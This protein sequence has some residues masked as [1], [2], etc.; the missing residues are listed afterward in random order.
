AGS[1]QSIPI[2]FT[3]GISQQSFYHSW[4]LAG[5][6]IAPGDEIEYYFEVWDNDGVNGHKPAR[7]Q[8]MIFHAPTENEIAE[9]TEKN[10]SEIKK[11][12][13]ES[14]KKSKELQKEMD[15]LYKKILEKK[16]LS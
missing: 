4:D 6:T 10:N 3:R 9:N 11:D 8:S 13:E 12:M 14:I 7:S 15:D 5:L 2:P 16:T 1:L